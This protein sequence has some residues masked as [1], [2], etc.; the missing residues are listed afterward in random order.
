M[1]FDT[2][3]SPRAHHSHGADSARSSELLCS[4]FSDESAGFR[5]P[6]IAHRGD[7]VRI[8][9]RA[10][11]GAC[12][13][14]SLLSSGKRE[15]VPFIHIN[16]DEHFDWYEA[17]LT[18]TETTLTYRILIHTEHGSVV[19][20]K[21]GCQ[22]LEGS[23]EPDDTF[24][25]RI[26]PNYDVP[27]WAHGAIMYQIMPDRFANA[28]T[29]NDVQSSEYAYDK[30][31]VRKIDDWN[32][33]PTI[34]DYRCFY[35]GDLQGVINKLDYLQSLGVEAIYFNP[36]FISPSSHGYDT[37]DYSHI[38]PHFG[39]I[40]QDS[41]QLLAAGDIDNAHAGS[42]IA[43]TT[44]P[45][46]LEATD[47]LFAELCQQIHARGMRIILDGVFNHCGSF[48][49]WMDR[50]AIYAQTGVHPAGAYHS[51]ESP[52]RRYFSFD[53][54][55]HSQGYEAWNDFPTLPKLDYD[56]CEGLADMVIDTVSKWVRPP[57]SID[58]WRLDVAAD[59]G[60]SEQYNHQFWKLF[61]SKLRS[62]NPNLLIFA[63]HYG[64]PA[65]WLEGD[66]WDSVM[67]YDAFMEP[68]T[69]FLTGMEKHSDFAREELCQDGEAFWQ[70]MKTGMAR[71]SW[72][73]LLSAMNEL[74]NHD[75]SRFLTRTNRTPGRVQNVGPEAA[76]FGIDKR[77][78][79]EAIFVQMTWPGA[80]TIYYGDE[81]GQVGWTDPDC[82]RTFPWGHEDWGLI[83]LHR[84]LARL[85]SQYSCLKTGS[86]LPLGG[87][88]G[89][90]AFG[91]FD[92][93][94]WLVTVVNNLD[95]AQHVTLR[96]AG[97]GVSDGQ[98]VNVKIKTSSDGFLS[99]ARPLGQVE[100]GVL[101]VCLDPRSAMVLGS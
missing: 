20:R 68:L 13:A 66:E 6:V 7:L 47:Q 17:Q 76:S 15:S 92:A 23:C 98:S 1:N 24:D 35:G 86:L 65:A 45:A 82:R 96:L 46:N 2:H 85:R 81:A 41:H 64:N 11:R 89:W 71:F 22:L 97:L 50:E 55:K 53:N 88:W 90:I 70:A 38:D 73:S 72:P 63:E 80:P 30:E 100:G 93:Q 3:P 58:G 28:D 99:D 42:Y 48:S 54:E 101:S 84:E 32:A 94:G 39:R 87:G 19:Y 5:N 14:A 4:F 36:L 27:E 40:T 44:A 33:A 12:K 56:H 26:I 34:D 83:E 9:L 16:S 51:E 52:Y 77:V 59:L 21:N 69:Y 62:I 67:N 29:S 10:E 25:F 31:H 75:H 37:Q 57:Y 95:E 91:R 79:R 8:R 49:P 78:L 18:C 74:S 61:R 43:R 60:H